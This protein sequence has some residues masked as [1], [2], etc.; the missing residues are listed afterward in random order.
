MFLIDSILLAPLKGVVWL[1]EKLNETVDK[2][3]ND[4]GRIKEEL[5][6]L[7]LQFE[8]DEISEAE[9]TKKESELLDRLD[10]IANA[11]ENAKEMEM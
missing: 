6:R 7:Q 1:G 5:M 3:L 10:A 11:E 8:L 4:T 2:E 9:Y